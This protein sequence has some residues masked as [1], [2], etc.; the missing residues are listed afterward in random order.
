MIYPYV[1][2]ITGAIVCLFEVVGVRWCMF[3]PRWERIITKRFYCVFVL[4]ERVLCSSSFPS[5]ISPPKFRSSWFGQLNLL[6]APSDPSLVRPKTQISQESQSRTHQA[7]RQ[8]LLYLVKPS[9]THQ[10]RDTEGENTGALASEHPKCRDNRN[11]RAS[12]LTSTPCRTTLIYRSQDQRSKLLR[13]EAPGRRC[14]S[15]ESRQISWKYAEAGTRRSSR[16]SRRYRWNL[17]FSKPNRELRD[18]QLP[19]PSHAKPYG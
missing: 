18:R 13:S 9:E 1:Q 8:P 10:A 5:V 15:H 12:R 6:F 14:M 16:S 19:N 11:A 17:E 2:P 7:L 4:L 3:P